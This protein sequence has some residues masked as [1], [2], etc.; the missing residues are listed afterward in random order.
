MSRRF[1][2]VLMVGLLIMVTLSV[3]FQ[4][5]NQ[6]TLQRILD[7][8]REQR[9][10][11][12]DRPPRQH[13]AARRPGAEGDSILPEGLVGVRFDEAPETPGG[14]FGE[15]M[16]VQPP[17]GATRV[18]AEGD[19]TSSRPAEQGAATA[20]RDESDASDGATMNILSEDDPDAP[21]MGQTD[22]AAMEQDARDDERPPS[23]EP[24]QEQATATAEPDPADDGEP[25]PATAEAE[26]KLEPEP[27]DP[28]W[29]EHEELVVATIEHLLAGEYQW[30]VQ[31]FSPQMTRRL[32]RSEIASALDPV[33]E[34]HGTFA[35]V[36][37]YE[38]VTS[39]LDEGLHAFRVVAATTSG[40]EM[41][42]TVTI[43]AQG[44]I[45]GLFM[46]EP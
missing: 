28:A 27:D 32:G 30:V 20:S 37:S 43:N 39:G 12:N 11:S 25:E 7:E 1:L 38:N 6:Q 18:D 13:A 44:E 45:D 14:G 34:S 40:A 35:E 23:P 22:V 19:P 15:P 46:R 26:P 5:Q 8:I 16:P 17:R 29:L 9:L 10:T 41:I 4:F 21:E 2:E 33:R 24:S 31:R 36:V 42:F 3:A